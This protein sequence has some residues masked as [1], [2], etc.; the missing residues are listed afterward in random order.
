MDIGL[1]Q[2]GIKVQQSLD[3]D[4][5]ATEVMKMNKHFFDHEIL[6]EDISK[7]LVKPQP[8]CDVMVFT[9]PCTKYS[10]IAD[11]HE[12]RTGDELY[13]HAL[14]HFALKRPEA[15]IA[16]N[17]PGMKKFPVVM[18]A[19]TA[20]PDYYTTVICPVN[21]TCWLPQDRKRLIIIGT[22]KP[23]FIT[24]PTEISN[25][26]RIKDILERNPEPY[27]IPPY[28]ITRLK[29]GYRDKPIIV[30][31]DQ[32]GAVAPCCVAHYSKDQGTRMVKDRKAKHGVR[33]FTIREY[34]RLQGVPDDY[35]FP[36]KRSSFKIIGNGVPVPM[37]RWVG[38]QLMSYFN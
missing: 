17:V 14:R 33:P 28:V 16:E 12:Q 8:D 29:G 19:M 30:D 20:M 6:T 21:T 1:K 35:K 5:E 11:I 25:R 32:P 36:D 4:P 38:L 22:K 9:Y 31:P 27:D 2:A 18:E 26:P 13:L 10:T 15:F 3:I 37:A 34:A 23:F 7:K 24:P